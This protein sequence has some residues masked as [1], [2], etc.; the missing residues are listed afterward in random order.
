MKSLSLQGVILDPALDLRSVSAAPKGA[1]LLNDY[2][3]DKKVLDVEGREVEV[4]YD[5]SLAIIRIHL[6]VIAVDFSRYSLL[7]RLGFGWLAR[8][9]RGVRQQAGSQTVAW[10]LVEPL[11]HQLGS[12]VGD[13]KLKLL[14]EE[15]AKMPPVDMARVLEELSH[16][17]RLAILDGL[18][19]DSASEA[20]EELDPKTQREL[21][22]FMPKGKAARLIDAMTPGQ[23]ADVLAALPASAARA[24]LELMDQHKSGRVQAILDEHEALISDYLVPEFVKLT[25]DISVPEARRRCQRTRTR[26]AAQCV[27]V[28]DAEDRVIGVAD[29]IDLLRAADETLLKDIM[30]KNVVTLDRDGTLKDASEAFA[31]YGFHILPVTDPQRKLLG[32]VPYRDVMNLKHRYLA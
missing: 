13:I 19:P 25:P 15:P 11:P 23:A 16:D 9:M 6:Y 3:V 28:V 1:V 10:N 24:I 31:R 14:K 12:F 30:K 4:V 27:F 18:E 26:D 32:I 21:I 20:L 17:Q 7:R 22:P 29:A 5:V 2:I 8:S